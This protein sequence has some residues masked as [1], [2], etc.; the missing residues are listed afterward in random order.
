MLN[1]RSD[2]REWFVY[3][4]RLKKPLT[5]GHSSSKTISQSVD[6]RFG[7]WPARVRCEVDSIKTSKDLNSVSRVIRTTV[8]G[9]VRPRI[10]SQ[11]KDS[12][13]RGN[14][15]SFSWLCT[16]CTKHGLS[17]SH[18]VC[19]KEQEISWVKGREDVSKLTAYTVCNTFW[20]RLRHI[21]WNIRL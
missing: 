20:R 14:G 15:I 4:Y 9:D 12:R 2:T 18:Q 5:S 16:N 19:L 1:R 21:E 7:S 8:L 13:R 10:W 11:E 6:S 3:K 17:Q